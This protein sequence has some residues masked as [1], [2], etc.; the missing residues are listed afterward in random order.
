MH[1]NYIKT[2]INIISNSDIAQ[3]EYLKDETYIKIIKNKNLLTNKVNDEIACSKIEKRILKKEDYI[4]LSKYVAIVKLIDKK[5]EEAF[6]SI[7]DRV[8]KGNKL[9]RLEY[10][11]IEIDVLSP[12]D[13]IISKIFVTNNSV[14]DY[15]KKMFS[16]NISLD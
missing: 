13:G 16:I 3:F 9:C 5:S 8:N 10:L 6:V 15:G 11:N 7:N 12:V 14:V 2:I 1:I 4:V